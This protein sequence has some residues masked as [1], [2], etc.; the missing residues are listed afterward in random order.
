MNIFCIAV[1]VDVMRWFNLCINQLCEAA[2]ETETETAC[3]IFT[4]YAQECSD[5]GSIVKWRTNAI[6]RK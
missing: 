2:N 3:K 4:A 5:E 1:K 6:C